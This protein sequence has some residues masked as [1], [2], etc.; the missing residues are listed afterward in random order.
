MEQL[1][2]IHQGETAEEV[3]QELRVESVILAGSYIDRG[4]FGSYVADGVLNVSQ[5]L[6]IYLSGHDKALGVSAFLSRRKRLG[7]MWSSS[8]SKMTPSIK[9]ALLKNLDK[10]DIHKCHSH[11]RS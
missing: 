2:L 4:V 6:T 9:Q 5:R 1:A 7:Q 3:H 11:R 8:L 10:I